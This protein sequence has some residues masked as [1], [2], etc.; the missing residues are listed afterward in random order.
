MRDVLRRE[1]W[2][3]N[4]LMYRKCAVSTSKFVV[5]LGWAGRCLVAKA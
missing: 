3:G 5:E 1:S 2:F 4:T